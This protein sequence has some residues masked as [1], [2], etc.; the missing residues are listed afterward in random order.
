MKTFEHISREYVPVN[1]LET[2]S[3]SYDT[4]E[5]GHKEAVK[6]A[7]DLEVAMAKLEV[8]EA[9]NEW[10]QNK[11]NQIKNIVAENT[12]YGN[13]YGALDNIIMEAGNIAADQG[14]I[15]RLQAQKDYL[16]FK[17]K[18]EN[19][20]TL[21]QDYKDYYL[22]NN[23]YHYEDKYDDKGNVIGGT[24]WTPNNS[25][26]AVIP[27][28]ELIVKGISIAAKESGGGTV[29][30]WLDVNGKP[31]TD[32]TKAFDGQVFNT[33]T[34]SWQKLDR[35]KIW[36][37]IQ[38]MIESTPG[39]KESLKQ[40]YDVAVW[41][42]K[43]DLKSNK[44]A[45]LASD[46][47]DENGIYLSEEQYLRKRIDPAVQAAEYYNST[48]STNY[49][50]G[51][52]T[53]KAAQA[54]AAAA[55]QA[56]MDRFNSG[57]MSGRDT[58][59]EIKVNQGAE[60]LTTKNTALKSIKD[61]YKQ[62]TGHPLYV[63][64][65]VTINIMNKLLDKRNVS[66]GDRRQILGL[67]RVYN[68]AVKNLDS[69]TSGMSDEDKKNFLFYSRISSGGELISSKNGGTKYDDK[70]INDINRLYGT[71]GQSVVITLGDKTL[72]NVDDIINAGTYDGYSNL[73][74]KRKGN[75][76]IIPKSAMQA[77]PMISSIVSKAEERSNVGFWST[78]YEIGTGGKGRYNIEVLDS[79]GNTINNKT[80][81]SVSHSTFTTQDTSFDYRKIIRSMSST[82]D[83]GLAQNTK[84]YSKYDINPTTIT[85]SSL[86][87]DGKSFTEAGLLD[88]YTRGIIS[89]EEYEKNKSYYS[90]SFDNIVSNMDFSQTPMYFS[91]HGGTRKLVINSEDRFNYG[92]EIRQAIK[93]KRAIFTPTVVPGSKDPISGAPI[94]GYNITITPKVDAKGNVVGDGKMKSFY[95]PGM[96]N[97]TASAYMMQQPE[98]QAFNT[99]SVVGSTRS[100]KILAD[101]ESNPKLGNVSITGLGNNQYEFNF[102]GISKTINTSE[103]AKATTAMYMYQTCKDAFIASGE[104]T[105]NP[106]LRNTIV[107]S[108]NKMAEV[109]GVDSNALLTYYLEDINK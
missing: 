49:G 53:Y 13:S 93:D 82:Y 41:K 100:T 17:E 15:G 50:N 45:P 88:Q 108:V 44:N 70:L 21:P 12:I 31:T 10:R 39:A 30:Q 63:E 4:L 59:V 72:K 106:R 1:D 37:G 65:G 24:K 27:L 57:M 71:N 77:I 89:K 98:M 83:E 48:S 84:L 33:T 97:E 7:S 87:L 78:V 101:S 76:I 109:L 25:P 94:A 85:V 67:V 55:S 19:N 35:K 20:N 23:P 47:T 95:I 86:N 26:K 42:H 14:T 18:V 60:F 91:E 40:D 64:E 9:E 102:G 3:K 52:A 61:I 81:N 38:S 46:V 6:A 105:M 22:A 36:A 5:Q 28:S 54:K 69:Y 32:P 29:T 74:I 92:A 99:M 8:N 73:G 43:Q 104:N 103:A 75:K 90:D 56:Q 11:I 107:E 66:A 79:N 62:L 34:N 16:A 80:T 58:P 51:L 96:I 2:L 68:E